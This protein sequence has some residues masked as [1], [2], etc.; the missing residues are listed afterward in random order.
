MEK[1]LYKKVTKVSEAADL[2]FYAFSY[3]YDLAAELNLIG[4]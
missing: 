3:Y 1:F 2:D 4:E